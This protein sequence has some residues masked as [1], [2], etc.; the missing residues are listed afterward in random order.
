MIPL[1]VGEINNFEKESIPLL[2]IYST[3]NIEIPQNYLKYLN[4]PNYN[5]FWIVSSYQ[6]LK[7]KI[8]EIIK[9]K[10]I[11]LNIV[12]SFE[13]KYSHNSLKEVAI[14]CNSKEKIS[15]LIEKYRNITN[16][17]YENKEFYY[18]ER[19]LNLELTVEEEQITDNAIIDVVKNNFNIIH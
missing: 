1:C 4:S 11:I 3:I 10:P 12:F 7:E 9:N 6:E 5:C 16:D 2:L 19:N 18:K 8:I 13:N 15:D 14:E 17:F